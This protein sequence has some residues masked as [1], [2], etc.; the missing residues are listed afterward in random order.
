MLL[1]IMILIISIIIFIALLPPVQDQL[2]VARGCS[3]MNCEG[4]VVQSTTGVTCTSEN[5]S[6]VSGLESNGL[7]CSV[8]DLFI[9]ILVLFVLIGLVTRLIH[10]KLVEPAP[11]E[12]PAYYG[13]GY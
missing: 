11:P 2:N 4:Y 6:Y 10:G 9:P 7:S 8:L 5:Q 3:Y 1:G 13:G 12:V